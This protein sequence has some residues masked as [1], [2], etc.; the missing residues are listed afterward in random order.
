ML[1]IKHTISNFLYNKK[2]SL[3]EL[4][5]KTKSYKISKVLKF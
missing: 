2:C 3:G 4:D 5:E 1:I